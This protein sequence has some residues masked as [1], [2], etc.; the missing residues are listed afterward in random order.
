MDK[1]ISTQRRIH[2]NSFA[3]PEL[4]GYEIVRKLGFGAASVIYSVKK[5]DTGDIYAVKHVVRQEGEDSRMIDQVETE[6]RVGSRLNHP[7]IRNYYEIERRRKRLKTREVIMKMEYCP[8]VSLE[9]SRQRSL[10]DLLLIFRMVADGMLGMHSQGFL[11]CDMKPNNIIIADTGA[12]RI[13]DLGQSCTIGTVKPR[14]QGTP[15][16]IAPEQVKRKHLNPRTDVFNLGATMYWALTGKHVPTLIPK[17][18]DRMDLVQTNREN[19]L[20]PR[21]I[22]SK[23]PIGVSNLVM[24]CVRTDPRQR[25]EDMPTLISRLDL[26][27]HMIAG[28]KLNINGNGNKNSSNGSSN[29]QDDPLS[30]LAD[31]SSIAGFNNNEENPQENFSLGM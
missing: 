22:K 11:H 17:Q 25:P 30:D 23:I 26:L 2:P 1:L 20:T 7:Y 13:I 24:E 6:F 19:P 14:I 18:T 4:P 31:D 27:I 28:G 8:G 21:Q 3:P 5:K 12:I 29:Q 16:Y 10:I 9:Q 15:D